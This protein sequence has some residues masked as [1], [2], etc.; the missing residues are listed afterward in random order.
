[1]ARLEGNRDSSP[2]ADLLE[3]R[4]TLRLVRR[5]A[6]RRTSSSIRINADG[7]ITPRFCALLAGGMKVL[8]I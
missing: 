5:R 7:E 3:R 2:W 4:G 6:S 8:P 1:L